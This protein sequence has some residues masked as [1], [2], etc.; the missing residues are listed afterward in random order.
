MRLLIMMLIAGALLAQAPE[1]PAPSKG[2]ETP[3]VP[4][5]VGT[6]KELMVDVIFPVSNEIFYVSRNENKT[7]K[8]WVDLKMY[9][10][11]LGEIANLL[12]SPVWGRNDERWMKDAKLLLDVGQSAYK[13]AKEKNLKGLEDL[14]NDLY[15]ACQSCHEHYRPGYRRRL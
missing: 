13:F 3:A 15:E 2:P 14:N 10:Y 6:M 4:K 1:A 11:T 5:R 8:D 9:S 12:M 7:E